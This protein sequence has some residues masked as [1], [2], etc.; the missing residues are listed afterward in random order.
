MSS[1]FP[2]PQNQLITDDKREDIVAHIVMVHRTIGVYSKKFL[3][4]LRRNNYVT[5]KN[6]LDFIN[7][8]LK[9]LLEKDNYILGQVGHVEVMGDGQG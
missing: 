2:P 3:Q 4:R 5:P 6:Y 7:T 1:V 8:Y 9:L